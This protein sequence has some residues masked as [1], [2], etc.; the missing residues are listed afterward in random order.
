VNLLGF[1][2]ILLTLVGVGIHGV[3]RFLHS[4]Q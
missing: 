1:G 2:V 3:L 4:R